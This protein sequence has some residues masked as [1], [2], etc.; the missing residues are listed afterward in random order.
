MA[1]LLAGARGKKME[2]K[3]RMKIE[4][5]LVLENKNPGC[6]NLVQ[7]RF[8][9]QAY[10]KS[11]W[12]FCEYFKK[13][14]VHLKYY[15]NVGQNVA[16]L[17]FP[18][19]ALSEIEKMAAQLGY[20]TEHK[21]ETLITISNLPPANGYEKWRENLPVASQKPQNS[22]TSMGNLLPAYKTSYDLCQHIYRATAKM[23]KDFRYELGARIR[24]HATDIME[25]LHLAA[26]NVG[27]VLVTHCAT[28]VH[29]LRIDIR[30]AKDLSQIT[31]EQWGFLNKQIE[32]LMNFL[33]AEF[34]RSRTVEAT[35]VQSGGTLSPANMQTSIKNRHG[36]SF[37][38]HSEAF[39]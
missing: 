26:N 5:I 19:T 38:S 35:Q 21:K 31:I 10:E 37:A 14:K 3:R 4:D 7:D 33:R 22:K 25:M 23:A 13:Y 6:I 34:L 9:W 24:S 28:L 16:L 12:L 17:G 11:C 30:L 36:D 1:W 29:K 18:K 27:T 2:K 8:F 20:K 32:E 39:S 15:K